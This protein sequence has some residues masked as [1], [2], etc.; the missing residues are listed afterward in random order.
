MHEYTLSCWY[1]S[2]LSFYSSPCKAQKLVP[3]CGK[4]SQASNW[5]LRVLWWEH[6]MAHICVSMNIPSGCMF[7]HWYTDTDRCQL[8]AV[9]IPLGFSLRT[10]DAGP[11]PF[12]HLWASSEEGWK[13]I[14]LLA[15]LD[16]AGWLPKLPGPSKTRVGV[17]CVLEFTD[18]TKRTTSPYPERCVFSC[19]S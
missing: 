8:S 18:S 19:P 15:M 4:Q 3:H 12:H 5:K 7:M 17:S 11:A 9:N 13:Q 10:F 2:L 16:D 6:I 14:V 1:M